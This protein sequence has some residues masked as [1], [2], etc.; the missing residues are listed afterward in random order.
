M[1]NKKDDCVT[2][3]MLPPDCASVIFFQNQ[4]AL[5][6]YSKLWGFLP[7]IGAGADT[8]TEAEFPAVFAAFR[9]KS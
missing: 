1:E 4:E 2:E 5:L 7:F 8:E 6:K 9:K 3:F